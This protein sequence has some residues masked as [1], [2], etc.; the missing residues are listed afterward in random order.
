MTPWTAAPQAPLSMGFPRQERWS[1]LPFPPPGDLPDQASDPVPC[2]SCAGRQDLYLL[3]HLD[4]QWTLLAWNFL[5]L[6]FRNVSYVSP[7]MLYFCF[8]FVNP[9]SRMLSTRAGCRDRPTDWAPNDRG[10]FLAI[11][12][13]G[14]PRGRCWQTRPCLGDPPPGCRW[15]FPCV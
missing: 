4:S 1:G 12:G 3:G 11:L 5:S 15:T 10:P 8:Y 2:G 7:L 14:T 13:A 6:S 9:V